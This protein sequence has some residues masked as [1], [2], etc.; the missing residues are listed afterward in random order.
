MLCC[1]VQP[2]AA[3]VARAVTAAPEAEHTRK[4]TGSGV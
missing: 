3:M 4:P 1:V 2:H